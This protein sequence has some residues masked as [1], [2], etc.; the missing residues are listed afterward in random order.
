MGEEMAAT[1][2]WVSGEL[3]GLLGALPADEAFE[4]A[5]A[6]YADCLAAVVGDEPQVKRARCRR[7]FLERLEELG[8]ADRQRAE[9]DSRLEALEAEIDEG[10]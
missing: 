4:A 10:T 6:S 2:G 3:D 9:I 1:P 5:R 8:V 7:R